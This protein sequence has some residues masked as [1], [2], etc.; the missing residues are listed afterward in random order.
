MRQVYM[1]VTPDGKVCGHRHR[2]VGGAAECGYVRRKQGTDYVSV[3]L[4]REDGS[5]LRKLDHVVDAWTAAMP[6]LGNYRLRGLSEDE[7]LGYASMACSISDMA[8]T[9]CEEKAFVDDI[10]DT[11][12]PEGRDAGR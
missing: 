7:L 4:F 8:R 10:T 11:M 6:M 9:R 12:L 1:A 2:S 5:I 3:L